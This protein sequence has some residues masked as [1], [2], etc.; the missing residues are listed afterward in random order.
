[1]SISEYQATPWYW[2]PAH[3]AI[4]HWNGSVAAGPWDAAQTGNQPATLVNTIST[5]VIKSENTDILTL[6][7][8]HNGVSQKF[9]MN[10]VTETRNCVYNQ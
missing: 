1:M 4:Y 9:Q 6:Y 3:G 5:T 8:T 10:I 7:V 2:R